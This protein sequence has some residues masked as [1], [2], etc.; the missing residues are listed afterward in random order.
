MYKTITLNIDGKQM[1]V[2]GDNTWSLDARPHKAFRVDAE[3]Y[4]YSFKIIPLQ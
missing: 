3:P 1:G 2:G 4:S